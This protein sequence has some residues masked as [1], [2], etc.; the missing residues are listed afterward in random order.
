MDS[1]TQNQP[2]GCHNAILENRAKLMLSGVTYIDSFDE[3]AVVLFTQLG[4]LTILGRNLH[5][6]AL[7][8]ESGDVSVEGDI[9]ALRYGDKDK[10]SAATL[11][12]R[13]FR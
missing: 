6:N 5:M 10:Q 1:N 9:Q 12:G 3:R 4:E 11:L 8:V 2:K 13:L 7:S